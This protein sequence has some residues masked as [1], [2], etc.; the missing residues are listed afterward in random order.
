MY[1]YKTSLIANT[2][3]LFLDLS[4]NGQFSV[5]LYEFVIEVN[6]IKMKGM[7]RTCKPNAI[8]EDL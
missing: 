1:I 8:L 5:S 7:L 3:Y 4:Q 2:P 6:I